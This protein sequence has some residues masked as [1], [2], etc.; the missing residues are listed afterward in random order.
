M[1]YRVGSRDHESIHW[2]YEYYSNKRDAEKAWRENF[3]D[4][5]RDGTPMCT[6]SGNEGIGSGGP[7]EGY[8]AIETMPLPR[9]KAEVL[10]MLR[11]W[12]SHG[13]NGP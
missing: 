6:A 13:E 11:I 7:W 1:I 9:N 8:D 4:E 5:G 12:A 10:R 3:A 2:G